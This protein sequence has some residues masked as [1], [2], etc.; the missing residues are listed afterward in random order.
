MLVPQNA[1]QYGYTFYSAH[2]SH[3]TLSCPE[4]DV[5]KPRSLR[6][7]YGKRF[8]DNEGF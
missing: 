1:L 2:C 5:M 3:G 8:L 6:V 7:I 4:V